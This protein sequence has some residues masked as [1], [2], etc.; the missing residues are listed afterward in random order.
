MKIHSFAAAVLI[1]ALGAVSAHGD[2]TFADPRQTW[3]VGV[4]RFTAVSLSPE[5]SYLSASFPLLIRETLSRIGDHTFTDEETLAYKITIVEGERE[6]LLGLRDTALIARD[7]D[8]IAGKLDQGV[9]GTTRVNQLEQSIESLDALDLDAIE[10]SG[11]KPVELVSGTDSPLL[12]E[13]IGSPSR[14]AKA[15][16][17]DLLVFGTIE[18]I[19]SYLFVDVRLYS[20]TFGELPM[21][22]T[23]FSRERLTESSVAVFDSLIRTVLGREWA[24]VTVIASNES[25]EISFDGE[26]KGLGEVTLDYVEPGEHAVHVSA[27]GFR[28]LDEIVSLTAGEDSRLNLE[29]VEESQRQFHI[30]SV[31]RGA[32]FYTRSQWYGTTPVEVPADFTH[33]Q[34]IVS[35]EG[36]QEALIPDIPGNTDSLEI[37]LLPDKFDRRSVVRSEREGFYKVLAA[38]FLSLPLPVYFFDRTN[39]LTQSYVAE[40]QRPFYQINLAEANRLLNLR[41]ISLSAYVGTAFI[42]VVLFIDATI[43]LLEY[44][45]LVQLTTY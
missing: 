36:Y 8:F 21:M 31:P 45:D 20:Y 28:P 6:R 18:E 25:A 13:V 15:S 32:D 14:N 38:F 23:A 27:L 34:G 7:T 41:Q 35:E 39:T 2:D 9:S 43:E 16:D 5:N 3:R 30:S 26:F 19:E 12:P 10:V 29:L 22:S 11:K 1:I 24:D 33:V 40:A 37:R 44:I 42:S 4:A 17:L